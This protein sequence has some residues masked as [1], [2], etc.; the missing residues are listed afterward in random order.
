MEDDCWPSTSNLS[1]SRR[2]APASRT[3]LPPHQPKPSDHRKPESFRGANLRRP[4]RDS[5][6]ATWIYPSEGA[7]LWL[8]MLIPTTGGIDVLVLIINAVAGRN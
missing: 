5:S 3:G 2:Q 4:D 7:R 8:L 6:H 1:E